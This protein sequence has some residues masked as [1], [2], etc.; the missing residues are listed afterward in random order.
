MTI[1]VNNPDITA[2]SSVNIAFSNRVNH[3][4]SCINSCLAVFGKFNLKTVVALELVVENRDTKLVTRTLDAVGNSVV[5]T[6]CVVAEAD[7][8]AFFIDTGNKVE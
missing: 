7:T 4:P 2:V 6:D 8:F 1:L 3:V 5:R